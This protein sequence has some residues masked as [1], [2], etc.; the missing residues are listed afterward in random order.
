[1]IRQLA[2]VVILSALLAPAVKA[3][4]T[5]TLTANEQDQGLAAV[6]VEGHVGKMQILSSAAGEIRVRVE[7]KS[8]RSRGR[9]RGNPDGVDLRSTRRGSTLVIGLSGDSKDLDET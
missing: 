6:E 5:R 7:I 4:D 9:T 3:Q 8:S 1:M 2:V